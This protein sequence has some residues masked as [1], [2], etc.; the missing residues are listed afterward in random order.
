MEK[1][2]WNLK[3]SR[4]KSEH[5]LLSLYFQY[6]SCK[7]RFV[8]RIN[9]QRFMY[10]MSLWQDKSSQLNQIGA[11]MVLVVKAL[12]EWVPWIV[13]NV[14]RENIPLKLLI[15]FSSPV[16]YLIATEGMVLIPSYLIKLNIITTVKEWVMNHLPPK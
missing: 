5:I 14:M 10:G 7:A 1:R 6:F 2:W 9:L 11:L 8:R 16:K 3:A 13:G 15:Y 4:G 12:P